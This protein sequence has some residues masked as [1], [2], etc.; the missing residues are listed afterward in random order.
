MEFMTITLKPV[1][2]QSIRR[3]HPWV[4]SGAIAARSGAVANGDIVRVADHQGRVLGTGHF[5][6]GS[7]AVRLFSFGE[8]VI[9]A[10]FWK[11]KLAHALASRRRSGVLSIP[12]NSIYRLVHA[13]GD[14]LPGL[15]I[16][17]YGDTAVIQAHNA[18][19]HELRGQFAAILRELL[20]DAIQRVYD[21]SEVKLSRHSSEPTTD[22]Y[23][24]GGPSDGL[25]KEHGLTFKIDW[26]KG[27]KTGFFI[28]QREN[29][30][31]L[32][33][34]SKG[35]K[36]LNT[37]CYTGGFSIY[38]LAAGAAE[39]HSLDSSQKALDLTLEN[40]RLNHFPEEKHKVIAADA[41]E[42][43]KSIDADYDV[44]VLD[45]PAFAKQLSARHKAVQGYRRINEAALRKIKSGGI[46]FTFSCSQAVDKELFRGAVL[47]AAIDAGREVRILHQLHQPPDHPVSLFH[48][49]GEYLKGLVL[50]V[51]SSNQSNTDA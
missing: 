50:E 3:F 49:E 41:V 17:I 15:I 48:P 34:M 1:K 20:G 18:G 30:R 46:L 27:Q 11:K 37:F 31:L 40:V 33:E 22:S 43:L 10:D 7:I 38:A 13:E 51:N 12:D 45:P 8:E 35:K 36:V 42:Y 19:M 5:S 9:N 47:A 16:D 6:E 28:D 24:F 25:C 14:G 39:V 21:K 4:F 44:I 29:R 26:E 32:G 23:L 2:E